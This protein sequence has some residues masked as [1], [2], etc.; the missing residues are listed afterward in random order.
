M[1]RMI[2]TASDGFSAL[3]SEPGYVELLKKLGLPAGK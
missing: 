1:P 2:G 3:Q